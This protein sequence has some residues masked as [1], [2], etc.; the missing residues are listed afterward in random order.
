MS[1]S[2]SSDT[3]YK[4]DPLKLLQKSSF[5]INGEKMT[6]P[7][8]HGKFYT[9][10]EM[11]NVEIQLKQLGGYIESVYC[12]EVTHV[13][14]SDFFFDWLTENMEESLKGFNHWTSVCPTK[15]Q[16]QIVYQL[17]KRLSSGEQRVWKANKLVRWIRFFKIQSTNTPTPKTNH[18]GK[19]IKPLSKTIPA[20]RPF[21]DKD[22][23]E[24]RKREPDVCNEEKENNCPLSP[25]KQLPISASSTQDAPVRFL[26]PVE[27]PETPPTYDLE[28]AE[29]KKSISSFKDDFN[30][31]TNGFT[32]IMQD[33]IEMKQMLTKLNEKSKFSRES[34]LVN[35]FFLPHFKY[36]LMSHKV[37]D[38]RG[39]INIYLLNGHL[40][41]QLL[42]LLLAIMNELE[43]SHPLA[44]RFI[45]NFYYIGGNTVHADVYKCKTF[46][47]ACFAVGVDSDPDATNFPVHFAVFK[48][49]FDALKLRTL[50]YKL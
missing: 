5:T 15:K 34:G 22:L 44:V 43:C 49:R 39:K 6:N 41:S 45:E 10:G 1:N 8:K 38:V 4:T 37:E 30:R 20:K 19:S 46:E 47:E 18:D 31:S 28:L 35:D 13:I 25:L 9:L 17:A 24:S 26:K 21:N 3:I 2:D 16:P 23:S 11:D 36:L 27:S 29:I 33:N 32:R 48:S 50:S 42:S 7:F 12:D 40:D 14:V